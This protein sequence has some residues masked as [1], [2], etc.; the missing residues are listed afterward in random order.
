MDADG[1]AV[2][3]AD[4]LRRLWVVDPGV[5]AGCPRQPGQATMKSEMNSL[6]WDLGGSRSAGWQWYSPS[7]DCYGSDAVGWS[8]GQGWK[9]TTPQLPWRQVSG[10]LIPSS[11]VT[12]SDC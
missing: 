12:P 5:D 6:L 1:A 11:D 3:A 8:I 4:A 7:R 10:S 2:F 9:S